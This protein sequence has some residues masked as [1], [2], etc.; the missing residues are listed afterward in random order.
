MVSRAASALLLTG[1]LGLTACTRDYT[2]AY[3]YA[4]AANA[5]INEYAVD[6]Q[7]GAL[8][9]IAGSPVAAGNNPVKITASTNGLFV[10]VLNQGRFDGT[11]VLRR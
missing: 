11:A 1:A 3:V 2:V 7:S 4:T 8:V 5:G 10:Y 9:P 6:Y